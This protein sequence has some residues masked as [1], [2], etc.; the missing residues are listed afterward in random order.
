VKKSREA[1]SLARAT[2]VL[3]IRSQGL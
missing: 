2:I 1:Y 3:T